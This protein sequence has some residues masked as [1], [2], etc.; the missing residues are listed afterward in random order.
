VGTLED[1]AAEVVLEIVG[2]ADLKAG[3]VVLSHLYL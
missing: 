2:A 3:L 1:G